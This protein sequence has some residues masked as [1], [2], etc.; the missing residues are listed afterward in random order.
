MPDTCGACGAEL[1]EDARFCHR[2][3]EPITVDAK[4]EV[5]IAELEREVALLN[6][7]KSDPKRKTGHALRT[8]AYV[9]FSAQCLLVVLY[10]IDALPGTYQGSPGGVIIAA[11]LSPVL[12]I[13]LV[14][15]GIADN[16]DG[17]RSVNRSTLSKLL[18]LYL[19]VVM[20]SSL[21]A[22]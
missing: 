10:G 3:S 2:C 14:L 11:A 21:I 7:E 6:S 1:A 16:R 20:V 8:S 12:W 13:A 9:L 5:R 18:F 19:I 4:N 22:A 17:I 15:A